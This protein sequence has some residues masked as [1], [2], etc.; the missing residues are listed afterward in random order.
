MKRRV[1]NLAV[2]SAGVGI[3][4]AAVLLMRTRPKLG[5]Q[6]VLITGGSRGLGLALAREFARQG[7][8]IAICA[9]DQE[10]LSKAQADLERT[11]ADVLAIQCDVTDRE[12]VGKLIHAVQARFGALDILV[13]NAGEILVAPIENV[14]LAD[15]ENA[16]AVMFWGVVYPTLLVIP[17]MRKRGQGRIATI[18]SIGGKISVPHLLPY[19]CAKFAAVGFTE[20]LRAEMA[21]YG[22]KVTT[23]VPGLMRTGSHLKARFK[24]HH[25]AE[26]AWFTLGATLPGISMDADRAARKI[27]AAIRCG[28]SEKILSP[29]A[30]VMARLNGLLPGLVPNLMRIAS[31]I[32]PG[33]AEEQGQREH[34]GEEIS[35]TWENWF[36]TLTVLGQRAARRLNQVNS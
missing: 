6:V 26:A 7:C 34:T 23:I 28:K 17:E 1:R 8:R 4:V 13:N 33:A 29:Q 16:M 10:E 14:T 2:G 20:G 31:A 22:V 36:A 27:V 12:S 24:G 25:E 32:L 3:G 5:S 19:C 9:R 18:T 15:F 21:P 11:S 35:H 30:S